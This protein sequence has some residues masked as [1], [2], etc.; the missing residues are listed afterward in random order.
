MIYSC[1]SKKTTDHKMAETD[2][3][4]YIIDAMTHYTLYSFDKVNR[5]SYTQS[6]YLEPNQYGKLYTKV[7]GI[8]VFDGYVSEVDTKATL[9][10]GMYEVNYFTLSTPKMNINVSD[11]YDVTNNSYSSMINS[12][13]E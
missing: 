5:Y 4:S 1:F 8:E 13:I 10:D 2:N 3:G 9:F 7:V 12:R 6:F 11:Y